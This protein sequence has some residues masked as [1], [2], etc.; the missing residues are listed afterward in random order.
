MRDS[1]DNGYLNGKSRSHDL[2]HCWECG[3]I[4]IHFRGANAYVDD[5]ISRE[6]THTCRDWPG[7]SAGVVVKFLVR[8]LA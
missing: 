8:F 7:V 6:V 2:W 5:L 3:R 4:G 1:L